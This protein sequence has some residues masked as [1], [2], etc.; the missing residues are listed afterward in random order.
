MKGIQEATAQQQKVRNYIVL[1]DY[2]IYMDILYN[3]NKEEKKNISF[4][5]CDLRGEGKVF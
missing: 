4:L 2:I 1:E 3:G 5:M